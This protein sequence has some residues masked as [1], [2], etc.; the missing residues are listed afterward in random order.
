MLVRF[1]NECE[2]GRERGLRVEG[3]AG[4]LGLMR[5]PGQRPIEIEQWARW[6]SFIMWPPL[7]SRALT[8]SH[9]S[10]RRK[11][12][13]SEPSI[14]LKLPRGWSLTLFPDPGRMTLVSSWPSEDELVVERPFLLTLAEL[15]LWG[16]PTRSRYRRAAGQWRRPIEGQAG[17]GASMLGRQRSV[18]RKVWVCYPEM[19]GLCEKPRMTQ[20]WEVKGQRAPGLLGSELHSLRVRNS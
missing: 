3:L 11:D 8:R 19:N 15:N 9:A 1:G 12:G 16:N 2:N 14:L 5:S 18:D 10:E 20:K 7:G 6:C 17:V 13:C 4:R